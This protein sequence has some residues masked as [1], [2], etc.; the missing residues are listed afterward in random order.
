MFGLGIEIDPDATTLSFESSYGVHG[1]IKA[2]RVVVSFE[3]RPTSL[4]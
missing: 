4:A 2:R 1:W 3:P